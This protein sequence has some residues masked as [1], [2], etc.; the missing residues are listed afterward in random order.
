[1][2]E[3]EEVRMRREYTSRLQAERAIADRARAV[4][5]SQSAAS[6]MLFGPPAGGQ[7]FAKAV[8]VH[9]SC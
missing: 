9:T 5:E 2:P 7:F 1:M 3:N 4:K 8:L 6:D